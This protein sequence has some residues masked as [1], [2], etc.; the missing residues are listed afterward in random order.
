MSQVNPPFRADQVGSL[1]RPKALLAARQHA[2]AGDIE[3][4]ELREI[5]DEHIAQVIK[6]QESVGMRAVTDGECRREF[7]HLD[8]LEQLAGVTVTGTIEA[9]SE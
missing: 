6:K 5:E 2:A 7:F 9:S 3:A 8:F 1:M 4:E